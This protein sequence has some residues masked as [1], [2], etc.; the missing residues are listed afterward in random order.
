MADWKHAQDEARVREAC[1]AICDAAEATARRN[2]T[3]LEYVYANY[4]SRDQNPLRS[5]GEANFAKMREVAAKYD[6]Q[7][8]FQTLQFGGWLLSK[9]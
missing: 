4:A 5:Y 8:V 7:G 1:R 6:P 9:A 3:F 2:G